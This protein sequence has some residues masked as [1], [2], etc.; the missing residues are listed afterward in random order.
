MSSEKVYVT[1]YEY[2]SLKE[3]EN[4]LA[5]CGIQLVPKQC[6]TEDDVIRE[7]KDADGLLDQYA[8]ISR[9][10]IENLPNL[11]VSFL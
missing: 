3:E 7:C 11:K 10:V 9:K 6:R 1:D 5:K 8:P 4:E 2:A